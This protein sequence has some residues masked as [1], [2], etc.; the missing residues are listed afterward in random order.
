LGYYKYQKD[1]CKDYKNYEDYKDYEDYEPYEDDEAYD[2]YEDYEPA[3]KPKKEE[4]YYPKKKKCEI[5]THVHEFAGSTK[6]ADEHNHRF[7]GVSSQAIGPE[8]YHVHAILTNTDFYEDH[9]H[10][11]GV[12]TGPPIWVGAG[13]HI[14]FVK[15]KTT[16]NDRHHHHFIFTTFIEDPLHVEKRKERKEYC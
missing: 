1:P 16:T 15:G 3:C 2:S 4:E 12:K 10:E 6:L 11:V 8:K 7:A 9:Y 14:H 5:Q 13:K